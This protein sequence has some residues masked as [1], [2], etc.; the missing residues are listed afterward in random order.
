MR[1][2]GERGERKEEIEGETEEGGRREQGEREEG[3][4]EEG[5]RERK[6]VRGWEKKLGE[7]QE[8]V[9]EWK[10]AKFIALSEYQ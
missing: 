9:N 6:M 8:R 4:R 2:D 3:E 1:R 5:E 10:I 7:R